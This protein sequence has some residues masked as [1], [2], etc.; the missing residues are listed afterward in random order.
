MVHFIVGDNC[1]TN[2]SIATKLSI[3]LI[4]CASH[5][6]NLAVFNYLVDFRDLTDQVH[7]LMFQLRHPNNFAD[8]SLHTNLHLVKA[9]A[10][11][12]SSAYDM[13]ERYIA[14]RDVFKRVAAVEDLVPRSAVHKKI[15]TR[16]TEM[17]S[18]CKTLQSE[19]RTLADVRLLF[20]SVVEK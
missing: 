13:L 9:N 19:D 3:L 15:V 7:A 1:S 20:N 18:V 8:L 10:T 12:W 14:I 11:R 4:S 2:Q 16:L 5:R 17:N 6:F